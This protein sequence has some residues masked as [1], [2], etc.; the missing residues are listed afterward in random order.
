MSQ[1]SDPEINRFISKKIT[2][3][4][5]TPKNLYSILLSK[6][7]ALADMNMDDCIY[8]DSSII[9]FDYCH[10]ENDSSFIGG[11]ESKRE[12]IHLIGK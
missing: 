5:L 2:V 12:I 9:S 11:S 1:L 4:F 7:L 10:N 8:D 6:N 3:T